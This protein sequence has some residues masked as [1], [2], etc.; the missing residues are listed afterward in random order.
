M[1]YTLKVMRASRESRRAWLWLGLVTSFITVAATPALADCKRAD[2]EAVVDKSGT[3]LARLNRENRPVLQR[4]L[5]ALKTAYAWSQ[6]EFQTKAAPIVADATTR[7]L[8][9]VIRDELTAI[10]DLGGDETGDETTTATPDCSLLK[11]LEASFDRLIDAVQTK[12][13][14]LFKQVD[15]AIASAPAQ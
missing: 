4:K 3:T 2:F 11:S 1:L 15:A 8:D 12:W 7:K 10:N 5:R 14:H 6:S 9:I 13:S